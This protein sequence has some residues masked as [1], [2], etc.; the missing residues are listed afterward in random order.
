MSCLKSCLFSIWLQNIG[1]LPLYGTGNKCSSPRTAGDRFPANDFAFSL[2]HLQYT[3]VPSNTG[4][5][6]DSWYGD[7]SMVIGHMG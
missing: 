4:W 7:V 5:I 6:R 1:M 3:P 2:C